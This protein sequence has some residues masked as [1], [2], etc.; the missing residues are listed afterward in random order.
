[1]LIT[2]AHDGRIKGVNLRLGST[3]ITTL[4]ADD[5]NVFLSYDQPSFTVLLEIL[6]AFCAASGG[7]L[8]HHKSEILPFGIPIRPPEWISQY[9]F[10][11]SVYISSSG[12]QTLQEGSGSSGCGVPSPASLSC[13][14]ALAL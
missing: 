10:Q 5:T 14:M 12:F 2:A 1:M 3:V 8:N 4:Y 13:D 11:S 6:S 9:G 7:K